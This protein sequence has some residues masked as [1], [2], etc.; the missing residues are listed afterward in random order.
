MCFSPEPRFGCQNQPNGDGTDL[1]TADSDV[2]VT[3]HWRCNRATPPSFNWEFKQRGTKIYE[4]A[5]P[6]HGWASVNLASLLEAH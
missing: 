3:L 1:K 5:L 4:I 2:T 6:N